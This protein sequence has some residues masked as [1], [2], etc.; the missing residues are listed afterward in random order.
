MP[1][2]LLLLR[3]MLCHHGCYLLVALDGCF[4]VVVLFWWMLGHPHVVLGSQSATW[5]WYTLC[6]FRCFVSLGLAWRVVWRALPI[7]CGLCLASL[8]AVVFLVSF[9]FFSVFSPLCTC[10]GQPLFGLQQVLSV[11]CFLL[12]EIRAQ[13]RSRKNVMGLLAISYLR[14]PA[15]P[16]PGP[17]AKPTQK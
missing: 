7:F 15:L 3:W 17:N 16:V 12:N 14:R 9:K 13:A 11:N 1:P 10:V 6:R 8:Q 5:R 4:A 2:L